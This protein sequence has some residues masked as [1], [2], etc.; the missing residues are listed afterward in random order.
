[1]INGQNEGE[2]DAVGQQNGSQRAEVMNGHSNPA[3][4]NPAWYDGIRGMLSTKASWSESE[5]RVSVTENGCQGLYA[6]V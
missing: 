3:L 5:E 1:M 2:A 6:H 4:P